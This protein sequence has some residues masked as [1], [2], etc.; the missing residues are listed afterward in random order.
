MHL[1][2]QNDEIILPIFRVLYANLYA[3]YHFYAFIQ[4][5]VNTLFLFHFVH[6]DGI[7]MN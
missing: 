4:S 1:L 5:F 3:D 2:F 7:D 6:K